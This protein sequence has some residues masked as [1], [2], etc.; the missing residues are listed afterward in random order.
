[1]SSSKKYKD[2]SN[3]YSSHLEAKWFILDLCSWLN[4]CPKRTEK[5]YEKIKIIEALKYR[6]ACMQD[7]RKSFKDL[8]TLLR[9]DRYRINLF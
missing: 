3:V 5:I 8:F 2:K 7:I 9:I 1:M 6:K 4:I